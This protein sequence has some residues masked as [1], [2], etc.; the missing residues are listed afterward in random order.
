MVNIKN[1]KIKKA[2]VI[3][4]NGRKVMES[5]SKTIDVSRLT[6]PVCYQNNI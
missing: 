4:M 2:E 5:T 1:D 6:W 3:D